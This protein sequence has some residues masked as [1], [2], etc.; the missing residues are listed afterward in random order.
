MFML[1]MKKTINLSLIIMI[2]TTLSISQVT[3]DKVAR[4]YNI[5]KSQVE[6]WVVSF[7]DSLFGEM[8]PRGTLNKYIYYGN[9][10][11]EESRQIDREW[12]NPPNKQIPKGYKIRYTQ[13]NFERHYYEFFL[14]L[15]TKEFSDDFSE[16]K[17]DDNGFTLI[18]NAEYADLLTLILVK[19]KI[20]KEAYIEFFSQD[21]KSVQKKQIIQIERALI[22]V[23]NAVK[24]K[25]NKATY[26]ENVKKFNKLWKIKEG[27][28]NNK[29]YLVINGLGGAFIVGKKNERIQILDF[30]KTID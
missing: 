8:N 29:Y 6:K 30:P 25:I 27:G 10:T 12:L 13:L 18:K 5:E 28:D 26:V 21:K 1:L 23:L 7:T 2:L 24:L 3:P 16:V 4:E 15:G 19:N 22:E 17:Y 9:L 14:S 20:S 11:E